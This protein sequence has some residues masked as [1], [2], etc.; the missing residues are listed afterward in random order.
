MRDH[1]VIGLIYCNWFRFNRLP[2]YGSN[3]S[4][5]PKRPINLKRFFIRWMRKQIWIYRCD[6]MAI[7]L[8]KH[9]HE[10]WEINIQIDHRHPS[11]YMDGAAWTA[12]AAWAAWAAYRM[13][14]DKSDEEY[15]LWWT[16]HINYEPTSES[17]SIRTE[18]N[19]S[20]KCTTAKDICN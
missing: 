16:F 14:Y 13:F 20:T 15:S 7:Q 11:N 8:I 12:W 18:S 9:Q 17:H 1:S 19:T 5:E 4:V 6:F 2:V 3:I 10:M